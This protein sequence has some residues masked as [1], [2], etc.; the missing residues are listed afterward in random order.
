MADLGVADALGDR[1][2]PA[3]HLADRVGANADALERIV[4]LL[5][6]YGVFQ[7]VDAGDF[8][9]DTLPAADAYVVMQVLHDWD[10]ARATRI[11]AGIKRVMPSTGKLLVME[12]PMTDHAGPNW[13]RILDVQML[14]VLGG[15]ERTR[16]E[17]RELLGAAGFNLQ[18]VIDTGAGISVLEATA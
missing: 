12:T 9:A 10:D 2:E 15:R 16:E 5:A 17:Y 13:D 1:P 7:V 11:L 18:Q 8:F 4:R 6:G 3:S 14:A